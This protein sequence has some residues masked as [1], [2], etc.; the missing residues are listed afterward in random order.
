M[1]SLGARDTRDNAG[2]IEA[3]S[4]TSAVEFLVPVGSIETLGLEVASDNVDFVL[5]CAN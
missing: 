5:V 4:F 2:Q 3:H 1:R